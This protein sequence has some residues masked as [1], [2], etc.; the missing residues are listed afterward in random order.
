MAVDHRFETFTM[1]A[2]W[3]IMSMLLKRYG[4]PDDEARITKW[5]FDYMNAGGGTVDVAPDRKP[6][7]EYVKAFQD[8]WARAEAEAAKKST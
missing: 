3:I 6:T 7:A 1:R 4:D 8:G 2:L 5:R